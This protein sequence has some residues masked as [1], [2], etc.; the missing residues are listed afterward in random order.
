MKRRELFVSAGA[1]VAT[2][3]PR[4][5]RAQSKKTPVIGLLGSNSAEDP[6][7][8]LNLAMFRRGLKQ[9]GFVEGQ[10]VEIDYRWAHGRTELLPRLA[11]ELVA[12]PVDVLVNE[13]GTPS[14][15]VAKNA[16]STI[17][18]VVNCGNAVDDGLVDNLARPGGNLTGFSQVTTETQTKAFQLLTELVPTART[19]GVISAG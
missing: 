13:G 6:A 4:V 10:N 1:A 12:R 7:I 17:P 8:A 18:I 3:V 19:V 11:A 2:F 15:V 5:P 9:E 14:A 16:T